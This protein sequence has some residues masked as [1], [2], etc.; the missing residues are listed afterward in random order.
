MTGTVLRLFGGGS[1]GRASGSAVAVPFPCGRKTF[2]LPKTAEQLEPGKINHGFMHGCVRAWNKRRRGGHTGIISA[3][4]CQRSQ[5]CRNHDGTYATW[6]WADPGWKIMGG[7]L[8]HLAPTQP[9]SV[10][11]AQTTAC[12]SEPQ[13][14]PTLLFNGAP[15]VSV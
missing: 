10:A 7:E 8:R 14:F 5:K 2:P 1:R 4:A 15:C 13:A 6:T 3:P 11:V 9:P 12:V